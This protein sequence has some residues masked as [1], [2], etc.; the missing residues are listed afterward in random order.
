M[1][2]THGRIVRRIVSILAATALGAVLVAPA[3]AGGDDA[4]LKGVK[5]VKA[6]FDVS[7]GSPKTMNLLFWAV[8]DV[9]KAESVQALPE[10]PHIVVV[11]H[12]PAV[13]LI[14]TDRKDLEESDKE[15]LDKFADTIRQMKK[16]GVK[17]DVCDYALKVM[18]VDPATIMP[19][20][21][22]VGNGFVSVVG[23]QA[24]GYSVVRIP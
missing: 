24:Q 15:E 6:V 20:V 16:D 19:E 1:N 3:M 23:Y 11:F 13:K 8:Q 14:S 17:L 7:Q 21:D 9:Y 12:G 4:A 22:H 18:G 5:G 10:P 2:R